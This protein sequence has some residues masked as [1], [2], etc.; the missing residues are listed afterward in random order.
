MASGH[1]RVPVER[2]TAALEGATFVHSR[3][4]YVGSRTDLSGLCLSCI[5][6]YGSLALE[7][8]RQ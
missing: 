7:E 5:D 1:T 2:C 3:C 4:S 8:F 6:F